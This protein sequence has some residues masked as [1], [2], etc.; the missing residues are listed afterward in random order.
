MNIDE[1]DGSY[2][3]EIVE[4]PGCF[5]WGRSIA[6]IRDALPRAMESHL[7]LRDVNVTFHEG[8][9]R[10]ETGGSR[11]GL[12]RRMVPAMADPRTEL[13]ASVVTAVG[14][15]SPVAAPTPRLARPLSSSVFPSTR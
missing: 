4:I 5:L 8:A 14:D 13:D 10:R 7:S 9:D 3:A 6:E 1:E 15:G 11:S 2:W 12:V